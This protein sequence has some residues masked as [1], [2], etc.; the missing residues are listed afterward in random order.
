MTKIQQPQR[1]QLCGRPLGPRRAAGSHR[2]HLKPGTHAVYSVAL[3]SLYRNSKKP[4]IYHVDSRTRD[5]DTPQFKK[6]HNGQQRRSPA[7]QG[8][9]RS[10][11]SASTATPRPNRKEFRVCCLG[12]KYLWPP[13][14]DLF[15]KLYIETII[16]NPKKVGFSG[17]S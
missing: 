17:H 1:K 11:T 13:K 16:R 12:F 6:P 2:S 14:T 3:K 9:L 8:S 10:P 4:S 5:Q 15:K 7:A